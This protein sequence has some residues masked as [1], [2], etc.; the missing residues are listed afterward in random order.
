[1][2]DSSKKKRSPYTK[3]RGVLGA[4]EGETITRRRLIT[5]G[6]LAAGGVA[7]AAVGLPALG[8]ALGPIFEKSVHE[9]WQDVGPEADFNPTTYVQKLVASY[10]SHVAWTTPHP[11]DPSTP[12]ESVKV[13]FL[14]HQMVTPAELRAGYSPTTDE[15]YFWAWFMG[16]FNRDG[17]LLEPQEPF[18]YWRLPIVKVSRKFP[19]DGS[20]ISQSNQPEDGKLLNC[21]E[22]HAELRKR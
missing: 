7:T 1:M 3:D 15:R 21:V 20:V 14:R 12:V 13:Y 22:I 9:G 2:A 5:G 6:A 10:A 8:F 4:F 18:L 11:T 16:E 19:Q 17:E